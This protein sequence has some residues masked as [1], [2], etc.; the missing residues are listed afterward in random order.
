MIIEFIKAVAIS[1]DEDKPARL[2]A[3]LAYYGMF[4]IAPI[5]YV[6]ITVAGFFIDQVT[7][8]E[9]LYDRISQLL[10]P[11]TAELIMNMVNT[12][13]DEA[14]RGSI[15][16]TIVGV[17]VLL[18]A[19]S[20]LFTNLKYAM[21][22][23]WQVP[24]SE[25]A[26]VWAF[27]K[28][29]LVAFVIVIGLGGMLVVGSLFSFVVNWLSDV[30]PFTSEIGLLN[31]LPVTALIY[32][33][34]LIFYR[35]LP[36]THVAWQDVWLAALITTIIY[37]LAFWVISSLLGFLDLRSALEAAGAVALVLMAINYA[38]QIFLLGAE[39]SKVYAYRVGSRSGEISVVL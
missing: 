16:G 23:I 3:G 2:A 20:G 36:E 5:L 14:I 39:I 7:I 25:Y 27:I 35:I 37:V 17:I 28:T 22:N 12:A 34:L 19:A 26:G 10:G 8:T 31:F 32:L 11:E 6:I 1:W 15:I 24:P 38:A 4:S 13:A 30:L 18:F 29:R 9:G 21:N 33:T